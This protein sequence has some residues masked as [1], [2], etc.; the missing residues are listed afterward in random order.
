ERAA[1]HPG[2]LDDE[3]A[4]PVH[5]TWARARP[6]GRAYVA[7]RGLRA[8]G[9]WAGRAS[10]SQPIPHIRSPPLTRPTTVLQ[11][12]VAGDRQTHAV[13][14]QTSTPATI[15]PASSVVS[16][17]ALIGTAPPRAPTLP[18]RSPGR[19]GNSASAFRGRGAEV[20]QRPRRSESERGLHPRN[21]LRG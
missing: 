12:T 18:H 15:R 8:P 9:G 5:V 3:D 1:H 4:G 13:T 2:V 17:R 7:L 6:A 14:Q 20:R 11:V 10:R 19:E 16:S 21:P